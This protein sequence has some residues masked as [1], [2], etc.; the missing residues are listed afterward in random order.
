MPNYL[1]DRWTLISL[2]HKCIRGHKLVDNA[3]LVDP[4]PISRSTLRLVEHDDRSRRR[5]NLVALTGGRV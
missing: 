3:C 2:V 4:S 5:N 1:T